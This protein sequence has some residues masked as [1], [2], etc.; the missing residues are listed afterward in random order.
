MQ[1]KYRAGRPY[2]S[3]LQEMMGWKCIFSSNTSLHFSLPE[4]L[5]IS[6]FLPAWHTVHDLQFTQHVLIIHS[7]FIIKSFIALE[8]TGLFAS[9]SVCQWVCISN[10]GQKGFQIHF[11][12]IVK[13]ISESYSMHKTKTSL[14]KQ[15]KMRH[16]PKGE[17]VVWLRSQ[18]F[19]IFLWH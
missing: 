11:S 18:M 2:I 9:F 14:K 10:S 15:K 4:S 5:V 16:W 13:E 8:S 3:L 17:R 1:L 7:Y 6:I 19:S 12:C